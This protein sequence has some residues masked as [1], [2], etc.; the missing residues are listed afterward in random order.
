MKLKPQIG[1]NLPEEVLR[2]LSEWCS[3][4]EDRNTVPG[5]SLGGI[6]GGIASFEASLAS[7]SFCLFLSICHPTDY[8]K[9]LE[10]ILTTP[11]PLYVPYLVVEFVLTDISFPAATLST[12]GPYSFSQLG[13]GD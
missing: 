13:I 2:C 10:Q 5:G 11:L 1:E 9:V 8:S 12:S 6:M 4:L 7:Q 3:V